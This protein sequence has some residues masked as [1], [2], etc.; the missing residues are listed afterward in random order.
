MMVT[1]LVWIAAGGAVGSVLRYLVGGWVQQAVGDW[2]QRAVGSEF[3][4][5]TLAVNVLGCFVLGVL[6]AMFVGPILIREEYRLGLTVGL[7]GGFTTFSTFGLETISLANDAQWLSAAANLVGSCLLGLAGAWLGY[8]LA[9][10]W[11][12]V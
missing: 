4:L 2:V 7:L 9:E 3:P 1:K 10:S 8:R 11:F 12:G 5:G 6:A